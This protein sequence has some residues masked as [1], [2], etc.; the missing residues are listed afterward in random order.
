M[1]VSEPT[2][3]EFVDGP[4]QL[5]DSPTNEWSASN[6]KQ[7]KIWL[8]RNFNRLRK[9]SNR[10]IYSSVLAKHHPLLASHYFQDGK[11]KFVIIHWTME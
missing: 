3:V 6:Y 4:T 7:A 1:L 8:P 5:S 11:S 9:E 2:N 10:F